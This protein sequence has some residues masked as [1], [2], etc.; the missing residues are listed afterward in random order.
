MGFFTKKRIENKVLSIDQNMAA[1]FQNVNRDIHTLHN[2]IQFFHSKINEQQHTSTRILE[3]NNR[4]QEQ[5]SERLEQHKT[6]INRVIGNFN[7]LQGEINYIKTKV[8]ALQKSNSGHIKALTENQEYLSNEISSI[9][10]HLTNIQADFQQE[11]EKGIYH[12]GKVLQEFNNLRAEIASMPKN[13]DDVKKI[14][15]S[16]YSFDDIL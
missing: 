11:M 7:I 10:P 16:Y 15:D 14:L 3:Q 8:D 12:Y 13:R 5:V 1:S 4:I 6:E 9:R 2:W